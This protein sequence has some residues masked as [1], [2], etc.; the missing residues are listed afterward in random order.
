MLNFQLMHMSYI[1]N[2]FRQ[3]GSRLYKNNP[4]SVKCW[5]RVLATL[6]EYEKKVNGVGLHNDFI[7]IGNS[8]VIIEFTNELDKFISDHIYELTAINRDIAGNWNV[9]KDTLEKYSYDLISSG[10]TPNYSQIL[11]SML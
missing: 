1:D 3:H 5:Q 8:E 7:I 11:D 2:T 10:E 4:R 9:V 6:N